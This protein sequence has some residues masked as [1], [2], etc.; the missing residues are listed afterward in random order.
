MKIQIDLQKD[1]N[2]NLKVYKVEKD[3]NSLQEAV[4][5]ILI[6]FFKVRK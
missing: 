2:K 3:L 5:D 4:I 1:L 6:K